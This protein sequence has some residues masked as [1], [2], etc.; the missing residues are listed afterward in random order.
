MWHNIGEIIGW[1]V[2][3]L[4]GL[5]FA[6]MLFVSLFDPAPTGAKKYDYLHNVNSDN[7]KEEVQDAKTRS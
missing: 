3:G 6:A 1:V 5:F 4:F 7:A 2:L